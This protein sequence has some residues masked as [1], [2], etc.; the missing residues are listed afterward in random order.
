[1]GILK[2]SI[3][4]ITLILVI[5][6]TIATLGINYSVMQNNKS[7]VSSILAAFESDSNNT[8][9]SL[10][11]NFA[12][13][14]KGLESAD[15]TTRDII[16]DLYST[17]YDTL[18]QAVAHQIFPMIEN[19]NYDSAG[20]VVTSMLNTTKEIKWVKFVTDE[21]P[22]ASD[23]YEFGKKASDDGKIFTYQINNNYSFL[24]IEMQ[25][26]LSGIQSTIKDVEGIFSK[27]NKENQEFASSVE[28]SSK[29]SITN[30]KDSANSLS[31]GGIKKLVIKIIVFMLLVLGLVRLSVAFFIKRWI[32]KPVSKIV[33]GLN[34]NATQVALTASQVSSASHSLAEET[35]Q[36]AASIEETSSSLEEMSTMTKQNAD[37]ANQADILM[38]DANQVV[39]NANDSMDDLTASMDEISKASEETSKIIKTIDEIAFQTNLLAL[40]AAVEAAR[41]GKAG[42]GFAVV[43]DEVRNLAMRAADAAHNTAELIE[44]TVKKSHDGTA[45]V[46]KTNESF[47]KVATSSAKV[48]ELVGEI[49]AA[50]NEQ[51]LGIGQVNSTVVDMDKSIQQNTA[52]AEESASAAEELSSQAEHVKSIV[53]ELV[54]LVEGGGNDTKHISSV[55]DESPATASNRTLTFRAIKKP[56]VPKAKKAGT[57]PAI[58]LDN[59][60]FKDF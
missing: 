2:K 43:A 27:I 8:I 47:D 1:M 59:D 55:G 21:T 35:S 14:V 17:S 22:T 33:V 25:V 56:T 37:N 7:L 16:L 19:F 15:Q 36:Q 46:I 41:A 53:K 45:L 6:F 42:A 40:N 4:G 20:E 48:G 28:M 10:N 11:K 23:I 5:V 57:E 18:I 50:S 26:S 31:R 54:A 29:Q 3:L 52:S 38:K 49:A 58:P 9:E 44:D 51:A 32:T 12:K 13:I 60:D 34:E 39:K 24:K 30:A